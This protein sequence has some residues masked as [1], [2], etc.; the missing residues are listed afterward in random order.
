ME[1]QHVRLLLKGKGIPFWQIAK[2]VG[3]SEPTMTRWFRTPLTDEHYQKI[4]NA[5]KQIEGENDA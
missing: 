4:M 1:N 2:V 5:I 3:I